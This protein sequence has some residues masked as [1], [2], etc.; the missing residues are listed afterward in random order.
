MKSNEETMHFEEI[1]NSNNYDVRSTLRADNELFDDE[2]STI[3][4]PI[5]NVKRITSPKNI[6][7]WQISVNG[8][9]VLLLKGTRFT[10]AEKNYLRTIEGMKF[11]ISEYKNGKKSVIKIKKELKKVIK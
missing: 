9:S 1:I 8:K 2:A 6:E 5:I 3:I 11:L 4:H 10:A 7:N